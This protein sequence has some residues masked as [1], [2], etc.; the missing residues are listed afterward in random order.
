MMLFAGK[1]SAQD[2]AVKRITDSIVIE[3]KA[4]YRSEWASWYGTDIFLDKCKGKKDLCAGYLSYE[5]EDGLNNIFF[6]KGDK[7]DVMVTTSFSNDFNP[8][9]YKLDTTRRKFT[10]LEK[11]LFDLRVTV[12][13]RMGTDTVFKYYKNTELNP[14]PI[15]R[16][17]VKRV[18][19]ITGTKENDVVMFGNDYMV[20]FDGKNQITP[21]KPLHKNIM[22]A[23]YKASQDSS[24][25]QIGAMHAHLPSSGDFITATDICTL[26]LY[27][28]FTSWNQ[29]YVISKNY[30]SIWDCKKN[31]LFV[32]TMAAWKRIAE[33]QTQR[34]PKQ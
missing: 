31:D 24:K 7:P 33:D 4:L 13:K 12:I 34:H 9:N 28:K 8:D 26:M 3:G 10:E 11:A 5:T 30:V 2:E 16:N 1:A 14:V 6:S 17:G 15:I 18:Y 29:Y 22:P 20:S 19:V 21:I 25:H 23:Y 32:M 27:E